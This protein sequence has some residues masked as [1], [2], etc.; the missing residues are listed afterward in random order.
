MDEIE[1]QYH[2]AIARA[3]QR[4]DNDAALE[5]SIGLKQYRTLYRDPPLKSDIEDID[6]RVQQ[7]P[8]L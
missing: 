8:L 2:V 6:V 1:R 4:F 7:V 3:M 5:L